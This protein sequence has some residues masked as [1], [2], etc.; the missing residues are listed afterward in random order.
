MPTT[1]KEQLLV[2]V[3]QLERQIPRTSEPDAL[4]T[5]LD[6]LLAEVRALPDTGSEDAVY[7]LMKRLNALAQRV[8]AVMP[9]P[10]I[11]RVLNA[12]RRR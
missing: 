7:D 3:H 6:A 1:L 12:D 11:R 10:S 8:A 9:K 2:G 5:E 4:N